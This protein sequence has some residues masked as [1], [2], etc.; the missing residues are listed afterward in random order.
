MAIVEHTTWAL[1]TSMPLDAVLAA[2]VDFGPN[3]ARIWSETAHPAVLEVHAL[4]ETWAEVTEG[5]PSAW[6][7]ERYDW[8]APG[9]VTLTQEDSN[10][11]Q[12]GGTIH[13]T[14][15]PTRLGTRIACDRRRTYVVSLDGLVA[16]TF[17]R[18]AGRIVLRWQF[19]RGL[20][21]AAELAQGQ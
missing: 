16:G 13:Y 4:G 5:V 11:A 9:V 2:I 6:S 7:R 15:T 21:R 3:R 12:P 18:L 1:E 8:S 14:L 17:M 10:V 19:A 20:A